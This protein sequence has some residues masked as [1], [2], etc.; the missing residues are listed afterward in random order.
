MET[1]TIRYSAEG[2][3]PAGQRTETDQERKE[4]EEREKKKVTTDQGGA[5]EGQ[6]KGEVN[7]SQLGPIGMTRDHDA[8]RQW[9]TTHGGEPARL[10]GI[11]GTDRGL[12]FVD[13]GQADERVERTTWEDFFYRFD[14]NHLAFYYD[15]IMSR[16][17]PKK[18]FKFVLT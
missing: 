3:Q 1:T 11:E 16:I 12:L 17:M 2:S 14:K 4:R 6:Q 8:I 9:I 5:R 18:S 10:R 7:A 15:E 13:F